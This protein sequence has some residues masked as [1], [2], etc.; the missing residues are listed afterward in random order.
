VGFA[1]VDGIFAA[2]FESPAR[3]L[4]RCMAMSSIIA[5]SWE[6]QCSALHTYRRIL[7]RYVHHIHIDRLACW[8][9]DKLIL[10]DHLGDLYLTHVSI[11]AP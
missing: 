5:R 3:W 1:V 10:F 9:R 11:I 8:P 4:R 6:N 7:C 2:G